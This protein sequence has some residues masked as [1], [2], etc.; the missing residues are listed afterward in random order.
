MNDSQRDDSLERRLRD[1]EA[2][3]EG[4]YDKRTEH[5]DEAGCGVF[6]NRLILEDSPYLLQHAHNPVNWYPWGE[7]AFAVAKAENRPVFLSIGYS[8][9]HWCHVM[10]VESFDNVEVARVLNRHFIAVKMDR[11]Q[12]PD[13]D[14]VY[15]TGV[16][17]MTGHGGWPMSNFLLPDGRP[18]FGATYFPPGQFIGL[19]RQ[20]HE[21]FSQRYDEVERSAASLHQSIE[22]ILSQR[23]SPS[24][25]AEDLPARTLGALYPREDERLGGLAGAPKFPQEAFL[26]LALDEAARSGDRRAFQFAERALRHMAM[27]GIHDHAAGGFHRY[28]VDA[29][30]LVPHFEKMLYNQSQLALAYLQA[31]RLGGSAFFRRTLEQTLDYVLRELQLPEG[32]FCSATD[33]DSEGREGAFFVWTMA[34]LEELFDE[35]ELELLV[36]HYQV[37][38]PGNFEGANIL[39]LS[40]PFPDE[41]VGAELDSILLRL[42]RI[43]EKREPPL[44]DDKL[45]AGWTGAMISALCDAAWALDRDDWL[46]AAERAA[47]HLW[48]ENITADGALRRIWLNGSASIDGQ[49]EDYA[50]FALALL[51]LADISGKPEYLQQA[52]GLMRN[53]LAL[54]FDEQ[55]HSFHLAPQ[56][57]PGPQL[58]RSR[59]ASDGAQI[60]PVATALECMI[61]LHRRAALL[62]ESNAAEFSAERI[63]GCIAE[64]APAINENP[65]GHP[66]LLR[67]ISAWES[68]DSGPVQTAGGGRACVLARRVI[69]GGNQQLCLR[70]R[71]APGWHVTAPGQAGGAWQGLRISLDESESGWR[72]GEMQ[73]SGESGKLATPAGET[74]EILTGEVKS[75]WNC[76]RFR[77]PQASAT[78]NLRLP[79]PLACNCNSATK[80]PANCLKPFFSGCK[81][82]FSNKTRQSCTSL[83]NCLGKF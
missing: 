62:P 19:L 14:E 29:Q 8:T 54:F 71:I 6:I 61:G 37:S 25:L 35:S 5:L 47:G 80:P 63:T 46:A 50:N 3:K 15:M 40:Q 53:A 48:R 81:I 31:W 70:M 82:L 38:T 56:S 34:E 68:G 72:L 36:E 17:C 2:A 51:R 20:V 39:H 76:C 42:R 33:A 59:N 66:S 69:A 30:W 9:C 45:I 26:L 43:R 23:H 11:E 52:A 78:T 64:L 21:V 32:G 57:T 74:V 49:L 10:E 83:K 4:A 7:E 79:P 65:V 55:T 16:Q 12:Y 28:S 18:F 73:F 44:R 27:G 22:R 13:I 24:P 77:H 58:T 75:R 60:S 1:A 67:V 41:E